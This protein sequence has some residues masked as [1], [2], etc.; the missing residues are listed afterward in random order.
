[1]WA[2][3]SGETVVEEEAVLRDHFG[4]PISMGTGSGTGSSMGAV[5]PG[6]SLGFFFSGE[7]A[8]GGCGFVGPGGRGV[9]FP[10]MSRSWRLGSVTLG[11]VDAAVAPNAAA[12]SRLVASPGRLL[13]V[14]I[15]DG[16]AIRRVHRN[17]Y[18]G[19]Y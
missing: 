12:V 9:D 2:R 11:L 8:S 15:A 7:L 16:S 18:S 4:P 13:L 14:T 6:C 1:M 17:S 10:S 5:E 19:G 3:S